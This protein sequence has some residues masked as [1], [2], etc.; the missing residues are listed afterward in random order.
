METM[1][2]VTRQQAPVGSGQTVQPGDI[3]DAFARAGIV[4]QKVAQVQQAAER[5]RANIRQVIV[6]KDAE[7]DL[8]LVALLCE[9]HVLIEDVPGGGKTMLAKALGRSLSSSF[10]LGS[11]F[12][13][14]SRR[15]W[16]NQ[17]ESRMPYHVL[18]SYRIGP[19]GA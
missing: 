13:D 11:G 1:P 17:G 3:T 16:N 5:V 18:V 10:S 19:G 15:A 12:M 8:L 14:Y 2:D 6:G 4:E 7:I 9:G